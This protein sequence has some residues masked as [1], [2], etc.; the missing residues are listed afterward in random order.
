M[1]TQKYF[2]KIFSNFFCPQKV[3]K[4]NSKSCL[5]MAVGSCFFLCSPACPKQPRTSFPFY[6]F[7]YTFIYAKICGYGPH[8]CGGIGATIAHFMFL[9]YSSTNST[10]EGSEPSWGISISKLK[11]SWK[12]DNI[13][14][15]CACSI[16]I[17]I[18][19]W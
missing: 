16:L 4:T 2:L 14:Q 7:F 18:F 13:F 5:F 19:L 1:R 10:Y 6:K 8:D 3:E 9:V 12:F 15:F 11:R 17:V